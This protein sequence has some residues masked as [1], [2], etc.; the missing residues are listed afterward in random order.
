MND[1]EMYICD[2]KH[3]WIM[4]SEY[5]GSDLVRRRVIGRRKHGSRHS[6]EA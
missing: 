4:D 1:E 3:N 6:H 5:L 2:R